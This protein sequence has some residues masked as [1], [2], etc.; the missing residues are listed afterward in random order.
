L[1]RTN[2]SSGRRLAKMVREAIEQERTEEIV[3]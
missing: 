2:M 1:W 3:T